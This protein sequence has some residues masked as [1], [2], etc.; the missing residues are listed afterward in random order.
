V[1]VALGRDADRDPGVIAL[2][3][4]ERFFPF[5]SIVP[6]NIEFLSAHRDELGQL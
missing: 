5:H 2:Q 3:Q 6:P 4:W 1:R